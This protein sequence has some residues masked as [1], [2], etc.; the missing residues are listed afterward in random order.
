MVLYAPARNKSHV[1][2]VW[3]TAMNDISSIKQARAIDDRALATLF[4]EART[5]NGFVDEPVPRELLERIFTFAML[6]PTSANMQPL[7]VVFVESPESK[8][9]LME[10]LSPGNVEKT[11]SAPV[12]AIFAA[13]TKFY[14][15]QPHIAPMMGAVVERFTAPENAGLAVGFA[16]MNAT[17]QGAYF[18]LAA[19]ALGLDVGP[20]AGFDKEKVDTIFFPDGRFKSIW[21]ANLGYGDDSKLFPRNPRLTFEEAAK[22]V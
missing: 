2:N 17:L 22:I 11:K 20:M 7:R 8:A 12:T 16:T 15:H 9:Q 4:T 19:R 13:D 6:G 3:S 10:T 14:E 1:S 18:M 5:A 21:L